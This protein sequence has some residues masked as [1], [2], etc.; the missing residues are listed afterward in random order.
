MNCVVAVVAGMVTAPE[1][2]AIVC[3]TAPVSLR[4]LGVYRFY[5]KLPIPHGTKVC[6]CP[7]CFGCFGRHAL[8]HGLHD[9]LAERILVLARKTRIHALHALVRF[10]NSSK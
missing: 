9:Q 6:E 10:V 2:R 8:L 1:G 5:A 4:R 3:V 7:R